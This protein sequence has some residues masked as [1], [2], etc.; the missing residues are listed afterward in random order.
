MLQLILAIWG[1]H[2][3]DGLDLVR[4][5]FYPSLC[6]H[7]PYKLAYADSKGALDWIQLHVVRFH[8]T[9]GLFQMSSV[10]TLG[11]A[12]YHNVIDIYFHSLT[13]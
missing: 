5:D 4:I 12:F 3:H 2:L 7:E 10:L 1:G 9:K 8:Q 6:N 13:D 11:F